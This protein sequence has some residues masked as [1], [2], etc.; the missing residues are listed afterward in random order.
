MDDALRR[1][2]SG[3]FGLCETCHDPIEADRL[4]RNP[5]LR[6]CLDHLSTA[7]MRAH[8]QDLELATRIQT[9]LLPRTDLALK[10]WDTHYRYHPA[11]VVGGDYCD[12]MVSSDGESLFFAVG[13]VAGKGVAA[14]LLMTH[15]SA[16]FR[17]LVSL[18]LPLA[19]LIARAN[20]LFSEST[21]DTHYATLVCGRTTADGVELCNAGHCRPVV[22]RRSATDRVEPTGLPLGLFSGGRYDVTRICFERG[23][24]MALYTDG[25]TE[26][27]DA[28]GNDYEEERLIRS[29]LGGLGQDARGMAESVLRDLSLFRGARP[30]ADDVTLL[31]LRRS[32]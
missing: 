16:I 12:L 14:S 9:K 17:S 11:G 6:F 20:R 13:D 10:G 22:V 1:I 2:D 27:Q 7:E 21:A 30:A 5:M 4:E 31:I 32:A 23:D 8:E 25:I 24:S 18:D 26:A 29:L 15:L 3:S 28:A 19:D